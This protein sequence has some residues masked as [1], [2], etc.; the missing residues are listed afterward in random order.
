MICTWFSVFFEGRQALICSD[1]QGA[2]QPQ[3]SAN[4]RAEK[5]WKQHVANHVI[6]S[7][8]QLI[9]GLQITL[10]WGSFGRQAL[11]SWLA[12]LLARWLA[13]LLV[14]WL[15]G[16]ACLFAGL[17]VLLCEFASWLACCPEKNKQRS[18]ITDRAGIEA[19]FHSN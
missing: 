14:C 5:H 6:C 18:N 15:A 13:G 4:Q 12:G 16:L 10:L 2:S 7:D 17:L 8:L 9:C 3:I 19:A 11:V 1:L